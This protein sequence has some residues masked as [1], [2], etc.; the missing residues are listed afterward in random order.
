MAGHPERQVSDTPIA[1]QLAAAL[2]MPWLLRRSWRMT[3]SIYELEGN[4]MAK[5]TEEELAV[6]RAAA[7]DKALN[8]DNAGAAGLAAIHDLVSGAVPGPE[9]K[10]D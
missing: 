4:S 7:V 6:L 9:E 1:E 2:D 8:G 5:P 10:T 3:G